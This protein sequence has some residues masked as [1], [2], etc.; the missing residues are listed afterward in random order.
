M[1]NIYYVKDKDPIPLSLLLSKF[2]TAQNMVSKHRSYL[3]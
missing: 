3:S 2:N 1:I